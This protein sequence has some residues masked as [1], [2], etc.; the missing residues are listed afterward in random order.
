M[1]LLSEN[2]AKNPHLVGLIIDV[3]QF[4]DNIIYIRCIYIQHQAKGRGRVISAR[5]FHFKDGGMSEVES[6]H[7]SQW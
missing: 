1:E 3:M 7:E 6:G 2:L 5:K 4:L